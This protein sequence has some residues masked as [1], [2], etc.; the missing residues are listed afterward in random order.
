MAVH[1]MEMFP[2]HGWSVTLRVKYIMEKTMN[3]NYFCNRL[4][5]DKMKKNVMIA[6]FLWPVTEIIYF[7]YDIVKNGQ[8]VY[9]PDCAFFLACNSARIGHIF[10]SVFQWFMPLYAM[11]LCAEDCI[12]DYATGYKN[13]LVSKTGR[14]T[15]AR[16]HLGKSFAVIF[17]VVAASLLL[18]LVMVH[19][20]FYGGKFSPYDDELVTSRFYQWEIDYPFA[21]NLLFIL[22][23]ASVAG[24]VSM[25]GT[26]MAIAF[27]NRKT[28]YGITLLLWFALFFQKNSVV[29]LFQPHSDYGLDTLV[30]L[31]LEVVILFFAV[32]L[33]GYL[34]EV[35]IE[36]KIN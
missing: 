36:K 29:I 20:V 12:E 26:M 2:Y 9:Y 31:G 15:Y 21:A 30:S 6:I 25:A 35:C 11:L 3:F 10:Q 18:N 22:V 19:I 17:L 28:A 32:I 27:H 8:P 34:K 23:S 1:G 33:A 13:I 5:A 24:L 16:Q 7:F 14:K 4:Y